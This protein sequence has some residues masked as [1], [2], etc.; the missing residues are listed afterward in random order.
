VI[1]YGFKELELTRI[2]A[3]VFIENKASNKLLIN[4]GFKKEGILRNYMY[5]NDV[6]FDTNLYSL[7]L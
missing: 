5:Q 1:S 2:G 7:L 6:S 4:L 3:I